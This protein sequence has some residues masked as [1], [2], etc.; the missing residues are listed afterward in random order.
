M[1]W[2]CFSLSNVILHVHFFLYTLKYK[3]PKPWCHYIISESIRPLWY[4]RELLIYPPVNDML[5]LYFFFSNNSC[6][7]LNFNKKSSRVTPGGGDD[8]RLF[9]AK[10]QLPRY[11]DNVPQWAEDFMSHWTVEVMRGVRVHLTT[12]SRVTRK[13]YK[14]TKT[15][16][17][18]TKVH[19]R[20]SLRS[21]PPVLRLGAGFQCWKSVSD[22]LVDW[23][24]IICHNTTAWL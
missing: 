12:S 18:K 1:P 9:R 21:P 23:Q 17:N 5:K 20:H 8:L 15:Y 3:D 10:E 6:V 22:S 14:N 19:Q 4:L 2:L 16:K 7:F 13:N 24:E 11:K